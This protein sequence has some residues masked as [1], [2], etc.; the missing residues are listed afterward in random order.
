[1]TRAEFLNNITVWEELKDFCR[2]WECEYCDDIFDEYDRDREINEDID[3]Y[4]GDYGWDELRDFLNGI[5]TGYDYYRRNSA[6]DW[7]G[8]DDDMFESYKYDVCEWADNGGVWDDNSE[9]EDDLFEFEEDDS[10]TEDPD[11]SPIEDED[12]SVGD[13]I[14]MCSV[15]FVT[16]QEDNMRKILEDQSEFKQFIDANVPKILK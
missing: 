8:A 13:L 6:F 15:A 9:E 5:P 12:F 14:G 11:E 10:F 4:C 2:D 16:I 1:M 7:D 3:E